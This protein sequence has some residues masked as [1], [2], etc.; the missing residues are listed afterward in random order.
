MH[1]CGDTYAW[2]RQGGF[3]RNIKH[4]GRLCP[5]LGVTEQDLQLVH[6]KV[7]NSM[8]CHKII[9]SVLANS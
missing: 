9:V 7:Y 3:H 8:D 6:L 4:S 2:E 5:V 1:Q